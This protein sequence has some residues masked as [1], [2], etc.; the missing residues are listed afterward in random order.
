MLY[1]IKDSQGYYFHN[2]GRI[3]LFET[4]DQANRYLQEFVQ[5]AAARGGIF[6]LTVMS[7]SHIM[8]VD[9]DINNV[10]CGTVYAADI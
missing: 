6:P 1:V 7:N 9:F 2:Q 5:Y 3:I 10:E 4:P 8:P